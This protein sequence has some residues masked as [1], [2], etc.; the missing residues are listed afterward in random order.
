MS[1]L[2]PIEDVFFITAKELIDLQLLVT[3]QIKIKQA[4]ILVLNFTFHYS[5][6]WH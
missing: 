1:L 2:G 3:E 6:L 5:N 4:S